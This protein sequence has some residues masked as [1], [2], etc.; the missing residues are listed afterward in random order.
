M[1]ISPWD[2]SLSLSQGEM[3][4]PWIRMVAMAVWE[5]VAHSEYIS[6]V[7]LMRFAWQTG[8]MTDWMWCERKR[9]IENDFR[10]W[11]EHLISVG[12]IYCT[13]ED[14]RTSI[15]FQFSICLDSD[16]YQMLS[17]DAVEL[18]KHGIPE[19]KEETV[20]GDTL[21][22]ISAHRWHLNCE[23]RWKAFLKGSAAII[24]QRG[25]LVFRGQKFKEKT[26]TECANNQAVEWG[27]PREWGPS[28]Q[29]K[30]VFWE[31]S[32]YVCHL[33]LRCQ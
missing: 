1:A 27:D 25:T 28:S 22:R 21:S 7:E 3:T 16:A 5:F 2:C 4:L 9:A 31:R 17:R 33:L 8:C 20:A 13:G 6:K 12:T 11:L 24:E 19:F 26:T 23:T 29:M 30:T 18:Y 15:K 14:D 32:H 10:V